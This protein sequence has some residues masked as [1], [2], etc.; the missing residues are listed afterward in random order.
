MLLCG[1]GFKLT[2]FV[3]PPQPSVVW[4]I[5][6]TTTHRVVLC[7]HKYGC[8]EFP[9]V[10]PVRGR[11]AVAVQ[12]E[13]GDRIASTEQVSC[14]AEQVAALGP[15]FGDGLGR[16]CSEPCGVKVCA[17]GPWATRKDG[18]GR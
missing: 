8:S 5:R 15:R 1:T 2:P 9:F 4:Q 18:D 14:P 17:T 6:R 10:K 3:R 12:E 11:L 13:S 7:W 16:L